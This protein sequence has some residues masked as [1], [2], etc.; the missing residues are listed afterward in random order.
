MSVRVGRGREDGRCV[1]LS[2]IA[3]LVMAA[4]VGRVAAQGVRP[5]SWEPRV[6]IGKA[7]SS[8]G[9][10]LHN[11][12]PGQAWQAL[13]ADANV[14]SRDLLL[15]LPGMRAGIQTQPK[16]VELTLWGNLPG[17]TVFSGLQSAVILHD[18]R[19]YDLDFT[20][21]R[22]RVRIANRKE[23]GAAR[24]WVRLAETAFELTLSEPGDTVCLGVYGFWPS[25]TPYRE[26]PKPGE[27]PTRSVRFVVLKGQISLKTSGTQLALSAPPGPAY[28]HWDNINGADEAAERLETVPAW[29]DA[30]AAKRSP[31]ADTIAGVIAKYQELVK[32]REPRTALLDLLAAAGTDTDKG[33]ALA[34][35][36]FAVFGLAALHEMDSVMQAL[37]D[38]KRAAIRR[39]AVI[40]LRHW[41]GDE[42]GN[43][44]R[45][46][47]LLVER[48]SYSKPQAAT[49]LQ[50]L[51]S[52]FPVDDPDTYETLIA[53]LRH[54][55]LAIRELAWWQLS[56]LVPENLQVPY[57]PAGSAEERAKAYRAWKE[58]IPSGSVPGRKS[59]R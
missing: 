57:D 48:Q 17:Q 59:K 54:R 2:A 35:A 18:S 37:G 27:G 36:E 23:S 46:V 40:A 38:D 44:R 34:T 58:R 5:V 24:V 31:R 51:H 8:Q 42:A 25:G 11:R 10:L 41:I 56:H 13:A 53:Y 29:A 7:M 22:G 32:D 26:T 14:M 52:A 15:A 49:V 43:D 12:R 1:R 9:A 4:S 16:A 33:R 45:L 28:Y 19:A 6:A 39:T 3:V 20:L 21:R 55:N 47:Q 50:L 30:A